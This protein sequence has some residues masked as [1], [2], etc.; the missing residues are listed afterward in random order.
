ME[1]GMSLGTRLN[2]RL[3][4]TFHAAEAANEGDFSTELE[5]VSITG[6]REALAYI[7]ERMTQDGPRRI[8]MSKSQAQYFL[9][10][11]VPDLIVRSRDSH[12]V[13]ELVAVVEVD[14]ADAT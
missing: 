6:L 4:V 10:G 7:R 8:A 14:Y 3:R 13:E 12:G 5:R 2:S 9:D 1:A 11:E